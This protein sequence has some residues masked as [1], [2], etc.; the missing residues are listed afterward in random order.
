[1]SFRFL[2]FVRGENSQS[3]VNSAGWFNQTRIY[4]TQIWM[5]WS[6][7]RFG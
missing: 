3:T 2:D 6:Q 5:A 4:D 1:M 7:L